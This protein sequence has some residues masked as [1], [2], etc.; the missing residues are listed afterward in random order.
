M[1]FAQ[2][3]LLAAASTLLCASA[4][5]QSAG[6]WSVRGAVTKITPQVE[7]GTLSAPAPAGTKSSVGADTQPTGGVTYMFNDNI[8]IDVPVGL[9]FKH[10]IFGEGALA[11]VG[12]IGSVKALPAT[13]AVQYRFG[14]AN[15]ML[16]PYVSLGG[17]YAYFFDAEGSAA[18][19][20]M[21]PLSPAGGTKLE[22][23]SKFGLTPGLGLVINVGSRYFVDASL[24]K[25][26]LKTTTSFSTGQKLDATLNPDALSLGFGMRF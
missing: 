10:K 1:R 8:A 16:R 12:Q 2:K 4:M 18:L 5:A 14:A 23:K 19:N 21:N 7:S 26:Y 20:A 22:V 9:G 24:S 17:T 15:S 11:G 25:T 3:T 13:V 6:S